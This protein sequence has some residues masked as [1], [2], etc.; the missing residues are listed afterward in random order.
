MAVGD[1]IPEFADRIETLE[2]TTEFRLLLRRIGA[3]I[4]EAL[5]PLNT[6]LEMQLFSFGRFVGVQPRLQKVEDMPIED[7]VI[8]DEVAD[9]G[10][11]IEDCLRRLRHFCGLPFFLTLSSNFSAG[12]SL[13]FWG[14][15]LP[16]KARARREGVSLST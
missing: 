3:F 15:S 1:M 6:V 16:E 9:G 10:V 11:P 2:K 13:G 12:S 8:K 14:T 5:H 4:D 7:S